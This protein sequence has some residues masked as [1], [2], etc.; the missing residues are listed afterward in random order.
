MK[1]IIINGPDET[2]FTKRIANAY[3]LKFIDPVAISEEFLNIMV[4]YFIIYF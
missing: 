4:K 1:N 3:N 2:N